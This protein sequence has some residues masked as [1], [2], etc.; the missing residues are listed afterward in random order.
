VPANTLA[1]NGNSG[2]AVYYATPSQLAS[3]VAD[4]KS[5]PNFGGIMMWDAGYSDANVN[6]GCNY[7]QE[8]KN[9]LL[10]G[11]DLHH[12]RSAAAPL[13]PQPNPLVVALRQRRVQARQ[14]AAQYLNGAR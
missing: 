11:A 12:H 2:G 9:I 6:N 13:R 4:T 8:A 5:S 10:T 1:A 3:I 7:A 14:E